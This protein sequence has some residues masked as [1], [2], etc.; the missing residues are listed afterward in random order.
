M[1]DMTPREAADPLESAGWL[2]VH[3]DDLVWREDDFWRH[4]GILIDHARAAAPA[5]WDQ[6]YVAL[7]DQ[8]R[9]DADNLRNAV[10]PKS[11]L[12]TIAEHLDQAATIVGGERP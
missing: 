9:L 7:A 6:G 3:K 2:E 1:S 10:L 5:R 12:L 8:W 11:V 4:V